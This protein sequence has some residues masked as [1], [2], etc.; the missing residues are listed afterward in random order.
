[1]RFC[2]HHTH[3]PPR[4]VPPRDSNMS[5]PAKQ[6]TV[7]KLIRIFLDVPHN[8]FVDFT[9][10]IERGTCDSANR[11]KGFSGSAGRLKGH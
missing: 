3:C 7:R 4:G 11:T 5:D 10:S 8:A 6:D 1:M 9:R 2:R